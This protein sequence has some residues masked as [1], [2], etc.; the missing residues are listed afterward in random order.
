MTT[1]QVGAQSSK[2]VN[3]RDDVFIRELKFALQTQSPLSRQVLIENMYLLTH[4]CL[5]KL[6]CEHFQKRKVKSLI[7]YVSILLGIGK[8]KIH[9]F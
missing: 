3:K 7:T 9:F 6:S 1:L 5:C 4:W 2:Y 8:L